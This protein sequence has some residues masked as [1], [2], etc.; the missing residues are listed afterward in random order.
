MRQRWKFPSPQ[1]SENSCV[2][3]LSFV[4][5]ALQLGE[6]GGVERLVV[7]SKIITST[8]I[9]CIIIRLYN[10]W[11]RPQ[12][13]RW[14]Q[15]CPPED[16]RSESPN[17]SMRALNTSHST[18]YPSPFLY[19]YP[20]HLGFSKLSKLP[21]SI[22]ISPVWKLFKVILKLSSKKNT[23]SVRCFASK[24]SANVS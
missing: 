15:R 3:S 9:S 6:A 10:K 12:K 18:H 19:S 16:R 7:C 4:S 11:G 5:V 14:C 13:R 20:K 24:S 23:T 22:W 1:K 21:I 17:T 2:Q 8:K